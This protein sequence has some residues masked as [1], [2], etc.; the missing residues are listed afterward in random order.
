[1][2]GRALAVAH[3]DLGGLLRD[4]L[5]REDADPDAPA[6]LDVAGHRTA[7]GLDLARRE[8]AALEGLQPVLAEGD[9]GPAR[10]DALVAAL[11]LLAVFPSSWL[12]HFSPLLSW[13]VSS[14][15]RAAGWRAARPCPALRP[16]RP[17]PGRRWCRRWSWPPKSRTRCRR[18]ACAAARD[19]R[20]TTRCGRFRRRSG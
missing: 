7:R 6:A 2:L 9:L 14:R 18:A 1:V 20:G 4:R 3:A 19:L 16:C 8:A 12:Q 11:L 17:A 10:G 13:R 5:V 15:V